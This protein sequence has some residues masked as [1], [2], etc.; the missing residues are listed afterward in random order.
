MSDRTNDSAIIGALRDELR[1]AL[2]DNL[3]LHA[4]LED[5]K[6]RNE[7][8]EQ[9]LAKHGVASRERFETIVTAV[10]HAAGLVS[11]IASTAVALTC[12]SY[13]FLAAMAVLA[14][15]AF[16]LTARALTRVLDLSS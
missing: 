14:C 13:S 15:G 5:A 1:E 10:I 4:S 3:L 6:S 2:K 8:L 9:R 11:M 7:Q 16:Y 12:G